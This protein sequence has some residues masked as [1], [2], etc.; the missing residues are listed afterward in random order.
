MKCS[1]FKH[2]GSDTKDDTRRYKGPHRAL[3]CKVFD[4]SLELRPPADFPILRWVATEPHELAT[5]ATVLEH[6]C[7][8]KF[9]K[10]GLSN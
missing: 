2:H 1:T 3:R 9:H 4:N 8:Q 7:N 10:Q 5:A 6:F